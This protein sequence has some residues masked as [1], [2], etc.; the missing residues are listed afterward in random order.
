MAVRPNANY[1]VD[2]QELNDIAGYRSEWRVRRSDQEYL[3]VAFDLMCR[4][5]YPILV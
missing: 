2:E 5:S 1:V 4:L 3:A